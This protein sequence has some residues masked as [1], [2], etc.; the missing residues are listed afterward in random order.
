MS[1]SATSSDSVKVRL[2][3]SGEIEVNHDVHGLNVDSSCAEVW[4]DEAPAFSFS[5]SV[6][7]MISFFLGHLG[8]NEIARVPK[9]NNL[10][11]QQLHSHSRITENDGLRDVQLTEKSVQAVHFVLLVDVAIVLCD[12]FQG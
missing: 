5:E 1:K 12:S 11:S 10:L 2:T 8:M 4:T 7:N 9:L 6:E 3:V